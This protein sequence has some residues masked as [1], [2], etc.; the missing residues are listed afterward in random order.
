MEHHATDVRMRILVLEDDYLLARRIGSEIS[1]MGD[2]VLG[3]FP[4]VETAMDHAQDA[5]A[6]ILDI[7]VGEGLSYAVADRMI[8]R[9]KPFLFYTGHER[10]LLPLHLRDSSIYSKP[11]PTQ[12]LIHDLRVQGRIRSSLSVTA[13]LPL[14]RERARQL[15]QGR[16]AA[17]RLLEATLET[18]LEQVGDRA[19][20]QHADDWLL[21]LLHR[22]YRR[23]GKGY[24]N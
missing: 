2:K 8:A 13:L 10:T 1:E 21:S 4:D 6:A 17:D 9:D 20:E 24:M 5:D 18:A 7:R 3:P 19:T 16:D 11:W 22:E 14:L 12:A 23:A 15:M